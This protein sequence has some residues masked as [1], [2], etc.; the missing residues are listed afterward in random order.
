MPGHGVGDPLHILGHIGV[1][2]RQTDLATGGDA[3]ADNAELHHA[4]LVL[5]QVERECLQRSAR[6]ALAGV[7]QITAA[8]TE[9]RRGHVTAVSSGAGV[10]WLDGHIGLQ[11]HIRGGTILRGAPTSYKIIRVRFSLLLQ[12]VSDGQADGLDVL[13]RNGKV[14]RGH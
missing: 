6:V 13:C 5:T 8:H 1:N 14:K 7:L 9:L 3:L 12:F 10:A 11:Q 2:A 4:Q